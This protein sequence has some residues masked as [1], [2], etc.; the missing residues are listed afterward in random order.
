M[1][2]MKVYLLLALLLCLVL[3]TSIFYHNSSLDSLEGSLQQQQ[4]HLSRNQGAVNQQS[5]NSL[6]KAQWSSKSQDS[7]QESQNLLQKTQWPSM[8]QGSL[9]QSQNSP[10]KAQWLS[11]NQGSFQESQNSLQKIQNSLQEIQWS[12]RRQGSLQESQNSPQKAQWLS[13][14]QGSLQE[15]QNSLQKT[16]WPSRS[17]GSLQESLNSVQNIQ[18]PNLGCYNK[19]FDEYKPID[20]GLTYHHPSIVHYA[21]LSKDN[22]PV[23]LTFLEYMSIMSAY[24]F[25]QPKA[26]FIH[27]YTQI[28]GKY[29]NEI[30][31]WT[32][33]FVEAHIIPPVTHFGN[34]RVKYIQHVA[35]YVKLQALVE[36]G[37]LMS[38]FD[39]IVINASRLHAMQRLSECVL[40]KGGPVGQFVNAGFISCI[41][42][43]TFIRL[44][45]NKYHEDYRPDLYVYNSS[46]QPLHIL[47][48]K[49]STRCHNVYL[50][51]T[52]CLDPNATAEKLRWKKKGGVNWRSKTAAHH[53]YK[54]GD[55]KMLKDKN[56]LGDMLRHVMRA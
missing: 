2:P 45:I 30:Q 40:S 25:L 16:R 8:R 19:K 13:M 53:F 42:N 35:D 3:T 52:V 36:F 21:K 31:T 47:E 51:S 10:Q 44:W 48:N 32:N 14:R 46:L 27:T 38:D 41:R 26:I 11:R 29:W 15:S 50:D 1:K 12:S 28:E 34:N 24:K 6:Q 17:Q 55:E 39:L 56:S 54:R 49:N 18:W 23:Q 9:Q 20:V 37:G 7:L 33:T 4:Q 22:H 5:Q 43:S